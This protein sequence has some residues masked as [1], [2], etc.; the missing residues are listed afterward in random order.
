[1]NRYCVDQFP[2]KLDLEQA[3]EFIDDDELVEVTPNNTR[4]RKRLL[5]ETERK[6]N[7]PDFCKLKI[8]YA[9]A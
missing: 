8:A 4:I 7:L 5:T 1:V 2:I 3:L 6:K 9:T